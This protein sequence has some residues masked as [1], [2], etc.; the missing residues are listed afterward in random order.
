MNI[1]VR[2]CEYKNQKHVA[3]PVRLD[4]FRRGIN[5][6]TNFGDYYCHSRRFAQQHTIGN[7]DGLKLFKRN[8]KDGFIYFSSIICSINN[9]D[10]RS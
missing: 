3:G 8:I 7:C 9:C 6:Q 10:A 4:D 2:V 5:P 1:N